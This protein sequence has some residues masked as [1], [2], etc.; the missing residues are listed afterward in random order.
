MKESLCDSKAAIVQRISR[1]HFGGLSH[2]GTRDAIAT[3]EEI[4]ERVAAVAAK[5]AK[6]KRHDQPLFILIQ[7]LFDLSKA[8]DNIDR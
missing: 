4:I 2:R 8:F 3:A 6:C 7:G 1:I 5:N